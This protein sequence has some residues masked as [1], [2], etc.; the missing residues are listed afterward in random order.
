MSDAAGFIV[1]IPFAGEDAAWLMQRA[2]DLAL[3]DAAQVV[4]MLVRQARKGVSAP[5]PVVVAIPR[6]EDIAAQQEAARQLE[7]AQRARREKAEQ[8][9]K[10][11]NEIERLTREDAAPSPVAI[12]DEVAAVVEEFEIAPDPDGGGYMP[13]D[14]GLIPRF[15]RSEPARGLRGPP[16]SLVEPVGVSRSVSSGYAQGDAAGNIIRQNFDHLGFNGGGRRA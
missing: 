5:P 4:R 2:D 16:G 3:E 6:V 12:A 14:N 15:L 9:A 7:A 13:G 1:T 8:I 10:L 11:R